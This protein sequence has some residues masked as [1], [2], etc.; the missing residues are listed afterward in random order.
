M[1]AA[2]IAEQVFRVR[3]AGALAAWYCNVMGM[4][5]LEQRESETWSAHYPGQSV[6]LVFKEAAPGSKQ[7]QSSRE[8]CY[9]KI[10]VCVGDVDLARER[11]IKQGTQV[12]TP[13]QFQEIGYLCHL[14]DPNGFTIELL[15]QTFQKNFVK[16]EE[17]PS[18]ALGQSAVLGQI[19]TRSTNI[20]KSL[21][22][23]QD[24]LGMK[25]LSVQDVSNFG[26]CLYFLAFTS[27]TPPVPADL[28]SVTNREWLW[29]RAYT[30]LEIQH[31]PGA[32]PASP[33]EEEGEGVHHIVMEVGDHQIY[34]KVAAQLDLKED[35]RYADPDGVKLVIKKITQK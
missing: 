6:R 7:Y 31:K 33:M 12:S 17:D 28:H 9:W 1:S 21:A 3:G 20:E 11:I 19:T 14:Q 23:Y 25:L 22:L 10:G 18:L 4:T 35:G 24:T 13:S 2:R 32:S 27:D 29:Q 26:F 15:Q 8:S 16:Q 34:D 30:T 5:E